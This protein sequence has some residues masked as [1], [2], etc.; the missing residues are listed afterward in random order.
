MHTKQMSD[1]S[2]DDDERGPRL[3]MVHRRGF[4]GSAD[5]AA[6][7]AAESE[8]GS[9]MENFIK[10]KVGEATRLA[11]EKNPNPVLWGGMAYDEWGIPIVQEWD[12]LTMEPPDGTRV[13][14][15][16]RRTGKSWL[17]RWLLWV[18]RKS[19]PKGIVFSNTERLNHW[20]TKFMPPNTVLPYK[21]TTLQA[22]HNVQA[23]ARMAANYEEL[24]KDNPDF[25]RCFVVMDDV[26]ADPHEFD[27]DRP[28]N[29]M[30]TQGRHYDEDGYFCTQ[31]LKAVPARCR[32]NSDV[33]YSFKTDDLD[34]RDYLWVL[35]GSAW[36]SELL[37]NYQYSMATL[38]NGVFIMNRSNAE[39]DTLTTKFYTYLAPGPEE[40]YRMGLIERPDP[41]APPTFRLCSQAL[42]LAGT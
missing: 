37:F 20:Y 38:G 6:G 24:A 40:Q 15:G 18:R 28:L 3:G 19:F 41:K 33:I 9:N 12:P 25:N 30:Y 42:W 32:G 29:T 14:Y 10:A 13:L 39:D 27:S 2:S 23:K 11:M 1:V 22:L 34:T 36:G 26:V 4:A 7:F 16:K 21:S 17:C 5:P 8:A 35:G 31:H